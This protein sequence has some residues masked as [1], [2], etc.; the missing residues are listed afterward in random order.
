MFI[1]RHKREIIFSKKA[2][3]IFNLVNFHTHEFWD[4]N[5]ITG[6]WVIVNLV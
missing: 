2:N 3:I 5:I 4:N 6:D 1:N